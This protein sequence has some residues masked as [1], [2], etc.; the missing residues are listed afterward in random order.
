MK[1]ELHTLF[2]KHDSAF[3][4]LSKMA[5]SQLI[6]KIIYIK[7]NGASIQHIISE[8]NSVLPGAVNPKDVE[9][10]IAILAKDKKVN[11]KGER[12]FIHNNYQ[13]EINAEVVDSE[14]LHKRVLNKYFP[15]AESPGAA[16]KVWFQDTMVRFFENFSFEW[17]HQITIKGR[18]DSERDVNINGILDETLLSSKGI[19]DGDKGWLKRQFVKFVDSRE[20]DENLL[21]WHYGITMFSSRLI[22][23][24]NYAD[25]FSIEMFK[26]SRFVL[27]TNILMVLDLE[28]H[29][30][31][32]S[33]KSLET[34][35]IALNICPVYFNRTKKEYIGAMAWRRQE[36]INVFKNYNNDVLK[37]SACPFIQTALQRGCC[38][39]DDVNR[40]FSSLLEV[41]NKF[42]E[43]LSIDELDY[44]E[45][46]TEIEKGSANDELKIKI[47]NI[48]KRRFK[49][50]K[51]EDPKAHD[52][53]MVSG[54]QFLRKSGK[55]WIITSDSTLK[56]FAIDNCIRDDNEIAIGLDVVI[57]LLAVNS[58]GVSVEASNYAP[59]F[60]NLVQYSLIPERDAFE[61]R[62]L[63]FMLNSKVKINELPSE[64]VIEI[65]KEVKKMRIS[66]KVDEEINLFLRRV[67]EGEKLGMN[68]DIKEARERESNA[69]ASKE[70]AENENRVLLNN[71]RTRRKGE[72]HD[73]YDNKLLKNR[74]LFITIPS[75]FAL[76]IIICIN[77]SLH[78][79]NIFVQI[80]IGVI[81]EIL[82]GIVP[83][84]PINKKLLKKYSEYVTDIDAKIEKEI[85]ELKKNAAS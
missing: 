77:C 44:A 23:A 15:N 78:N 5:L 84:W 41:P 32:E 60:K 75:L 54:A 12:H 13:K 68:D 16:I 37:A 7:G 21:F 74:I 65:A 47:N 42:H 62:D 6:L 45:L 49:K 72:L 48:Y 67:I 81:V 71:Y 82:V 20:A 35:L 19:N 83:L 27:D 18:S 85:I 64:R 57:G 63:A 40:M 25:E 51:K 3:K 79:P 22:T 1:R 8:L 53:G 58:G 69:N 28:A 24:R 76:G 14:S 73:E 59:L 30:L 4:T 34:V 43:K 17:F 9:E 26:K 46:N 38:N 31:R 10:A 70:K 11:V 56:L 50:D 80:M 39:E 36:T 66:G 52:A 33:L 2:I 61:I 29:K 55:C